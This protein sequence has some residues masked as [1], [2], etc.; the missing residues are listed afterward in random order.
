M[1]LAAR[2]VACT[3]ALGGVPISQPSL[4]TMLAGALSPVYP[5]HVNAA[6]IQTKPIGTG[7]FRFVKFK[8]NEGMKL[9]KTRTIGRRACPS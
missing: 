6:T 5:C 9:A 7:P 4:L 2:W 3:N 1:S 8:Q